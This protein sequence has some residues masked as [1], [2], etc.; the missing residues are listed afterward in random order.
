[1]KPKILFLHLIV[2]LCTVTTS[3]QEQ[4]EYENIQFSSEIIN[5]NEFKN[6][7]IAGAEIKQTL[8]LF[9]NEISK[10]NISDLETTTDPDGNKIAYLPSSIQDLNIEQKISNLNQIKNDLL[11]KYPQLKTISSS[12]FIEYV[13]K[14]IKNI[15][16]V[17]T[18]LTKSPISELTFDNTAELT[19]YLYNWT[20]SPEY[21]EV[22]IY[23]FG[24]GTS[25]VVLD[26]ANTPNSSVVTFTTYGQSHFYNGKHI[27]SVSHTH[28][29]SGSPSEADK[30]LL[31]SMPYCSHSI[32]YNGAFRYYY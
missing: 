12:Q 4:E 3:C 31:K 8:N 5:S 14:C 32:F 26:S 20:L 6:F 27:I 28:R 21:V 1:M 24:D 16:I 19:G 7:I 29:E 23:F 9:N 10:I 17:P 22:V 25:L 13:D 30:N 18:S 2:T 15:K 11:T